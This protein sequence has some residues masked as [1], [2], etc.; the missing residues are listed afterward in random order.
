M[1]LYITVNEYILNAPNGKENLIVLREIIRLTELTETI[2]T[3]NNFAC[4]SFRLIF[5][6]IKFTSK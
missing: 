2:N 5:I 1:N 4:S 6:Q 3:E